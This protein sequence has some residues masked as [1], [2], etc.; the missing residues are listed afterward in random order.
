MGGRSAPSYQHVEHIV[1]TS[2]LRRGALAARFPEVTITQIK[3]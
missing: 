1:I 2:N 3:P